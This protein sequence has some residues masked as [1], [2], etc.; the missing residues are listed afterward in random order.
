MRYK[1][2]LDEYM[3]VFRFRRQSFLKEDL[4]EFCRKYGLETTGSREELADRIDHYLR[5]AHP[6]P[7]PKIRLDSIIG[8]TKAS[9]EDLRQFYQEYIGEDFLF[10]QKLR[11]WL[12]EHPDCMYLESLEAYYRI[13]HVAKNHKNRL[14]KLAEYKE[15]LND[16]LQDN[17]DK[18]LGH[19]A[20]C[21]IM[22]KQRDSSKEYKREDLKYL[23]MPI[24]TD[25]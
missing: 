21:W 14:E 17:P 7:L 20:T 10:Y 16:F 12:N 3:S 15:Y 11:D 6:K 5:K 9:E 2:V 19:A 23:T 24:A 25:E 1:P 8:K 18:H 22:K 4:V 13:Y